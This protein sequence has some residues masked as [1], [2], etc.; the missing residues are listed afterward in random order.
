MAPDPRGLVGSFRHLD[1]LVDAVK[2]A[3]A[4]GIKVADVFS[5]V[6]V[7]EVQELVSPGRSPVR[8]VTF[9]GGVSGLVAGMALA[10]LTSQVWNL[11]VGGKPVNSIIPF[12]VVGFELTILLGAI[13]TLVALFHFGRLPHVTFP[14]PAYRAEFSD[15]RFG[16]WLDCDD[17]DQGAARELLEQAGADTVHRVAMA[18]SDEEAS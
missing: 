2:S 7:E 1:E 5:P 6:P 11:V 17:A 12:L 16:L 13:S 18:G 14:G 8:F 10:L 3:Q 4:A 9:A 15:D